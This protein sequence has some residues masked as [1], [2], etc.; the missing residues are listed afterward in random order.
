MKSAAFIIH[1]Q[2]LLE[3]AGH[4]DARFL[5]EILKVCI[6]F[7]EGLASRSQALALPTKLYGDCIECSKLLLSL[8]RLP[9][10]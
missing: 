6:I 1:A 8:P 3:N 4:L 7:D 5:S 2:G 10:D 9:G